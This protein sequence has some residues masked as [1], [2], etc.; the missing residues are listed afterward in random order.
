MP[1]AT[2][3]EVATLA[4]GCFWCLDTVY[5]EL[6]GVQHVESGYAGGHTAGPSYKDV[7]SGATGHAEVVQVTFDPAVISYRD[8]LDVFFTIHDPTT[9]NRQ[10]HDI[11]T[12]YRSAIFYHDAAQ[13]STANDII[14]ELAR[15]GIWGD[16]I[17]TEVVPFTVFYPAEQY[18]Q[19]YYAQN[20][21]QPYCQVVIAPKVAK[22]RK[23]FFDKLKK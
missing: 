2:R 16:S 8:L 14:A 13:Q 15:K 7:C 6:N 1:S 3:A 9:L 5:R 11:G 21:E 20:L 19:A 12:Q 17:V 10:G 18:H 22:A 4:G 23:A